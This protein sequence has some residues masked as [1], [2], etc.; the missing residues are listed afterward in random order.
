MAASDAEPPDDQQRLE[1]LHSK[2]LDRAED[3]LKEGDHALA[4]QLIKHNNITAPRKADRGTMEDAAK[5][6]A[7]LTFSPRERMTGSP[8]VPLRRTAD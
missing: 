4:L 6:A 1:A 3:L 2:L 5:V 7:K 8:V